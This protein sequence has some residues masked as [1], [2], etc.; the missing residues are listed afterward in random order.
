LAEGHKKYSQEIIVTNLQVGWCPSWLDIN[1][2]F[3]AP[4]LL[5]AISVSVFSLKWNIS[6]L[7][8]CFI[9]RLSTFEGN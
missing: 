7:N 6:R 4:F 1:I 9:W 3:F 2:L 5:S 8:C